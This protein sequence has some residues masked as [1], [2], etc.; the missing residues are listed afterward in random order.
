MYLDEAK[1]I[2]NT[3]LEHPI[4]DNFVNKS[5][6][7]KKTYVEYYDNEMIKLVNKKCHRELKYF[8]YDFYGSTKHEPLIINCNIKYN[9]YDDKVT[10]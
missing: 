3:K 2:L 4:E 10:N 6:R 5:H 8:N 9:V 7:K 1:K